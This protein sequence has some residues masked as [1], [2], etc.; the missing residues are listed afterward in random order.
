MIK[1]VI[2][3][4]QANLCNIQGFFTNFYKTTQQFFEELNLNEN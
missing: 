3:F 4:I 2:G 1:G